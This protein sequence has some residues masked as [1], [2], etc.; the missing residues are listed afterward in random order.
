MT[1]TPYVRFIGL[2]F[3]VIVLWL[4]A[5]KKSDSPLPKPTIANPANNGNDTTTVG[6]TL[7]LHP[8]VTASGNPTYA[9]TIGGQAAGA[10]SILSFVP[11]N[12]GDQQIVV[13]VTNSGGSASFTYHVH[14]YAAYENGFFIL[15]EGNYGTAAGSVNFYRYNTGKL[16]ND[17]FTKVNPGKDLNP[18][19]GQLEYGTI[20]DGQLYLLVKA[21]GPIVRTDAWSLKETGRIA[22]DAGNDWRAFLGIDSTHALVS[23]GNGI[24]PLDLGTLTLGTALTSVTG[25]VDDM[26]SAGNY[27]FTLS[28]NDGAVVL[29]K[30]TYSAAKTF[31]DIRI[32]FAVSKDG[33]V[34]AA[35]TD[36]LVRIDPAT[37]DTTH[38]A[39]P[40]TVNNT[41]GFWHPGSMTSSTTENAIF[42][43]NNL[44]F[45]GATTIYKYVIG[46][47]ASLQN[48]F[49]NITTNKELYG[50][51]LGFDPIIH[52][53]VVT[54]VQSGYGANFA[55]ND[56]DFYD[57]SS[58][59]LQTDLPYSGYFFPSTPVFH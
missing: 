9:W 31:S 49:I 33:A 43:A 57:G 22:A 34:W 47:P 58:A 10:D 5:C 39:L 8:A 28:E 55:V 15:N 53:L 26:V 23:S 59:V 19:T 16:E 54:T 48:P 32:S 41:F 40:F 21:G 17:I 1:K 13:T 30:N 6:D 50:A 7:V 51:G 24:I 29:N 25:D 11:T 38:V 35:A 36:Y 52:N 3:T 12:H 18:N 56:L 46:T 2:S 45:S 4:A 20:W 27:I 44:A 14:V 42:I 37:L